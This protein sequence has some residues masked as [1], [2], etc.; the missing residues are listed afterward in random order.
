MVTYEQYQKY[1]VLQRIKDI[2]N[3]YLQCSEGELEQYIPIRDLWNTYRYQLSGMKMA[4]PEFATLLIDLSLLFPRHLDLGPSREK[5]E[6]GLVWQE[7]MYG[8]II[9]H[10]RV[11]G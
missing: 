5:E 1:S 8:Y 7:K 4:K 3:A 2:Q 11:Y 9:F 6:G 10:Q